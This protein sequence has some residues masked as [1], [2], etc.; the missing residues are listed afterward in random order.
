MADHDRPDVERMLR[1]LNAAAVVVSEYF[2]A[3]KAGDPKATLDRLID[4]LQ[5]GDLGAAVDRLEA[6]RC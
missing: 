4:V 6:G 5:A 2:E 1:A 3:G